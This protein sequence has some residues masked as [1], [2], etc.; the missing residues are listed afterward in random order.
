MKSWT[1][2]Q[3]SVSSRNT[4]LKVI[5]WLNFISLLEESYKFVILK[6]RLGQ[7]QDM[8][9]RFVGDE[10]KEIVVTLVNGRQFIVHTN[11]RKFHKAMV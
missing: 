2:F 9:L 3:F 1:R 10:N 4:Y 11:W 5:F 7:V 8:K 6:N